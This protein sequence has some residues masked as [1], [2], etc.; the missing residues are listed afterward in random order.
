MNQKLKSRLWVTVVWL[1]CAASLA[2]GLCVGVASTLS[3]EM[4]L[5]P[6]LPGF[7]ASFGFTFNVTVPFWVYFLARINEK[8]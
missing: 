2:Y 8:K 7:V 6:S 4:S 5:T 1:I 3:K